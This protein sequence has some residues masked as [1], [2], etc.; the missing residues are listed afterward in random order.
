MIYLN[1]I[2]NNT[3][4]LMQVCSNSHKFLLGTYVQSVVCV[5]LRTTVNR[6]KLQNEIAEDFTILSNFCVYFKMLI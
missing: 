1:H 2:T 3:A 5:R 6:N 4:Y